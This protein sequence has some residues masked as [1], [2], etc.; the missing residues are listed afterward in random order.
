MVKQHLHTLK[1]DK[2]F[3]DQDTLA[4]VMQAIMFAIERTPGGRGE[5]VFTLIEEGY[6]SGRW[7]GVLLVVVKHPSLLKR[8]LVVAEV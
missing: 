3:V 5:A 2:L 8:G 6:T 1:M 7:S 4:I